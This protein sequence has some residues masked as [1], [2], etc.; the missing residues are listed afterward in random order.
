MQISRAIGMLP[1]DP[2]NELV[3][4]TRARARSGP[5]NGTNMSEA[6]NA[7]NRVESRLTR[8]LRNLAIA[9]EK[10]DGAADITEWLE[11]F[12]LLLTESGREQASEKLSFLVLNLTGDALEVYWSLP[13]AGR[14]DYET[15]RQALIEN[16]GHTAED[17]HEAKMLLYNR[18]QKQFEPLKDYVRAMISLSKATDLVEEDKVRVIVANTRPIVKRHLRTLTFKSAREILQCPL[19]NDDF[20]DSVPATVAAT[21]PEP[22]PRPQVRFQTH[23]KGCQCD[24]HRRNASR[25]R[26]RERSRSKSGDRQVPSHQHGPPLNDTRPRYSQ[27]PY[28]PAFQQGPYMPHGPWPQNPYLPQSQ[29]PFNQG[30]YYQQHAKFQPRPPTCGKCGY[31]RCSGGDKCTAVNKTCH[32]CN[33]IGHLRPVC[34]F[35]K[36]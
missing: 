27:G 26:S 20:E 5:S 19:I 12:D 32:N 10:Y 18:K 17:K 34:P 35:A 2:A 11:T 4:I 1:T 23:C 28:Q 16:F 6:V 13:P 36:R 3:R 30:A 14:K 21:T 7:I 22:A 9:P 33:Q 25:E 29:T 8:Q 31:T 15:V 24:Q